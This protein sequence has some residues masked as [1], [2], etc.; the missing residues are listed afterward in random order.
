MSRPAPERSTASNEAP[1]TKTLTEAELAQLE[2]DLDNRRRCF[3]PTTPIP[4]ELYDR[5]VSRLL[6]SSRSQRER[7]RALIIKAR[8]TA[9]ASTVRANEER[10][11]ETRGRLLG[12]ARACANLA[13][14]IA[15]IVGE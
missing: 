12:Q 9:E 11:L 3:G 15:W 7:L 5:D 10:D 14:R 2:L 4:L 13:E 8:V 6:A 1:D